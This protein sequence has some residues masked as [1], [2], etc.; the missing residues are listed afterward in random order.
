MR[1]PHGRFA[2]LLLAHEGELVRL[3]KENA[4]LLAENRLMRKSLK[5]N[6]DE[7]LDP[8]P[9]SS[10]HSDG[11]I[12]DGNDG[13]LFDVRIQPLGSTSQSGSLSGGSA[14]NG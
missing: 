14:A 5:L 6:E 9:L 12:D 8:R 13:V 10:I 7:A 4:K 1:E 3:Q 2:E 11:V